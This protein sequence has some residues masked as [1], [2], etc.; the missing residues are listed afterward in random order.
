MSKYTTEVRFICENSAGVIES[1]GYKSI[2]EIV[3]K[4]R[5]KIFDFDYPI[6]D[7]NYRSVIECKILKH[8]YT[9]EIGSESVGLWKLWLDT[10]LNEIMPYYNQLYSSELIKFNPMYDVDLTRDYHKTNEGSQNELGGYSE[11]EERESGEEIKTTTNVNSSGNGST[12]NTGSNSQ[13]GGNKVNRWEYYSDT[14]QGGINGLES[15]TYLTEAR[16]TT[17]DGSESKIDST[18]N[19]NSNSQYTDTSNDVE[20][21]EG[22]RK[23]NNKRNGNNNKNMTLSNTEG[24][25]EHVIGKN[26]GSSY[27][28]RLIEY[29]ETFL[30][31]DTMVINELNDLFFNLW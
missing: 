23:E 13:T 19:N 1:E 7:E 12:S 18:N 14:P 21:R 2:N 11:N 28:K 27:S 3:N 26:G 6:F 16:H 8:F 4:A 24:Y 5:Q 25:L 20:E 22:N 30:N 17:D 9:R 31:I 10:R 29:R 15:L